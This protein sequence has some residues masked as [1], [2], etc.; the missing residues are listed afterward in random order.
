MDKVIEA[1]ELLVCFQWNSDYNKDDVCKELADVFSYCIMFAD[2]MNVDIETIILD[3]VDKTK[4]KY[5]IN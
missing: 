5:P 1:G 4:K 2:R 3:K